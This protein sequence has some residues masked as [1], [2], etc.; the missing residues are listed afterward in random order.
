MSYENAIAQLERTITEGK[1]E[2]ENL[3][4][5]VSLL[6]EVVLVKK[7]EQGVSSCKESTPVASNNIPGAPVQGVC[8]LI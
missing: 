7:E 2:F 5:E 1:E 8:E 3:R 4:G 6:K